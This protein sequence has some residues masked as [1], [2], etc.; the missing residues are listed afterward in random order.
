MRPDRATNAE[1]WEF[2]KLVAILLRQFRRLL[3]EKDIDLTEADIRQMGEQVAN[4]AP[5]DPRTPAITEALSELVQ[6][7]VGA[8][9]QW[10]LTFA[11]SLATSMTDMSNWQTTADFLEVANEKIN[12]E[13]RISAGVSLMVALGDY[14]YA[15]VLLQAID[16][17]LKTEGRLDVDAVI[18]KRALLFAAGLSTDA[19]D[20]RGKL[21]AWLELHS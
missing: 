14:R 10:N 5:L 12:A 3:A 7:S 1:Y 20:W 9:A 21:Q 11:E 16:H 6:E 2:D 17:D 8:L 18:A 13:V 19:D 15:A 4:R